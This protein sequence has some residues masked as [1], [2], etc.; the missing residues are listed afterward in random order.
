MT[1]RISY[2]ERGAG[3]HEADPQ[4]P[5]RIPGLVRLSNGD[6][7]LVFE[8]GSGTAASG[9]ASV[10]CRWPGSPTARTDFPEADAE[11]IPMSMPA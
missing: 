8:G 4:G 1:V 10:A 5:P 11:E 3:G 6:V 9:S 2:D 7:G